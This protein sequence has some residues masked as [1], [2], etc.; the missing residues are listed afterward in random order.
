MNDASFELIETNLKK[1]YQVLV[2]VHA[3]KETATTGKA[4]V[5]IARQKG[6]IKLFAKNDLLSNF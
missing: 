2:F 1:E 5:E 6:Q 3:R 4:I